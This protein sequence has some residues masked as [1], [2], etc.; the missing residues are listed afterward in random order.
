MNLEQAYQK[1]LET[2]EK[3]P[4][5]GTAMFFFGSAVK[6]TPSNEVLEFLK[7]KNKKELSNK[8]DYEKGRK[9]FFA[10]YLAENWGFS[11]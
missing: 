10:E 1:S 7:A 5:S 2:Y 6:R 11:L 8:Y 3:F 4:N 9:L